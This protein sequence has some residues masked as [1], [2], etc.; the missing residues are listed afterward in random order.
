MIFQNGQRTAASVLLFLS[1]FGCTR[2]PDASR[3]NSTEQILRRGLS[4]EPATVDPA[5][6][7]D[8]FS[9]QVVQDLYEGLTSESST[10]DAEPAVAD[11]WSV[12]RSGFKYTFH[13]R[14][15]ARWSNGVPVYANDF[16]KAWQREL[17]PEKGSPVSSDL[18][19]IAGAAEIT[20]GR[21]PP[22]SL[23]AVAVNDRE[24]EVTLERPAAYFPQLLSHSAAFPI[25]SDVSAENH[26]P[27]TW[28]SNGAYVLANWRP[29]SSIEL[30]K[31]SH[32]WNRA[33]VRISRVRYLFQSDQNAQFSAYR[34]GQIDITDVVPKSALE[35]LN[36]TKQN[37]IVIAPYAA[38][39]YYALNMQSPILSSNPKLRQAL[40]MSVDRERLV[41]TL[42]LG[43]IA[44]YSLVPPG[45]WNYSPPAWE[46]RNLSAEGRKS[47][48]KR[49]LREAGFVD[50]KSLH[51]RLLFNSNPAIKQT[52]VLIAAM[53]KE[54]LGIETDFRE[55]EFKV[56][57][58]SRHDKQNWDV[59]RVAWNADYDD[60]SNFLDTLLIESRNNDSGYANAAFEKFLRDASLT[61]DPSIRKT[62]L[63]KAE[64]LA[65]NDYPIIPLYHLVSKHLVKPY[66]SGVQPG[67][68][69]RV[70]SQVLT[71]VSH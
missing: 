55:E 13:I 19:L 41:A 14:E 51:I 57:L 66:V 1:L 50:G 63:E 59:A 56:Y 46:W 9:T 15:D 12:N 20:A 37:E 2:E 32:Y 18:Q 65:L 71:I 25:Y 8:T 29:G 26:S 54:D 39:A 62:I 28:I 67:P 58:E 23:G 10:G 22:S 69:D 4:G 44:A 64:R 61:N 27:E 53:W 49:L 16:V 11:S 6:A 38:T 31:N 70:R 35:M 33:S 17:S 45:T 68:F 48:A 21:S 34:S 24:L 30:V 52:A 40:A 60:A 43:Q 47:E 7:T 3:I 42:G 36:S 5:Y